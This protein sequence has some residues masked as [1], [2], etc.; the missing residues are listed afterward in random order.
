MGKS[1]H[2]DHLDDWAKR[3]ESTESETF[4]CDGALGDYWEANTRIG[5]VLKETNEPV[6]YD[7]LRK[8]HMEKLEGALKRDDSIFRL[9]VW[10]V[11]EEES[12]KMRTPPG[13]GTVREKS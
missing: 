2:N 7:D 13:H 8:H 10:A 6:V 12:Y 3:F 9:S 11:L 1:E 4:V 5:A